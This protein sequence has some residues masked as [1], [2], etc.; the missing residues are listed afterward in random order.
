MKRKN[1]LIEASTTTTLEKPSND[2][3]PIEKSD[4]KEDGIMTIRIIS[5]GWGTS[6]YYT[7]SALRDG[8]SRYKAGTLMFWDHP[9]MSDEIERPE[10]SLRDLAGVL[11]TDGVFQEGDAKGVYS[12]VRVF[13]PYRKAVKELAQYIG[14]SHIAEGEGEFGEAEGRKGRLVSRITKV[15]SVDF[16]TVPGAGGKIMEAFRS[17]SPK[18]EIEKINLD[19][20]K[21]ERPDLVESMKKEFNNEEGSTMKEELEKLQKEL[22]EAQDRLKALEEENKAKDAELK[23]ALE[24]SK[25]HEEAILLSEAKSIIAEK[26]QEEK[27]PEMTSQRIS[28]SIEIPFKEGALDKDALMSTIAERVLAE[29]EYIAK[30]LGGGKIKDLGESGADTE[31]KTDYSEVLTDNFKR[32]GLSE[33]SAKEASKGRV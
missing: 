22:K 26:L 29:K 28:D 14:I 17:Y 2:I 18:G 1:V 21:K 6:G 11:V 25:R 30:V 20:L 23:E 5:P 12:K 16:V 4:L 24:K 15:N 10:R 8:A 31:D 3:I 13:E 27:L 33:A 19:S 9:K 32:L 7:E